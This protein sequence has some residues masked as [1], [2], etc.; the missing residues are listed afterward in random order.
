MSILVSSTA[1]TAF[2][3]TN[4]IGF[5]ISYYDE[6]NFY[7]INSQFPHILHIILTPE[8][9]NDVLTQM[10]ATI[11]VSVKNVLIL[12]PNPENTELVEMFHARFDQ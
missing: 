7:K 4:K 2:V 6:E 10:Y 3:E 9:T 11:K 1:D 12:T 8:K 5:I